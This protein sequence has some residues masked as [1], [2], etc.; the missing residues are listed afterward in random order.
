MKIF[1]F[2]L[3]IFLSVSCFSCKQKPKEKQP[4]AAEESNQQLITRTKTSFKIVIGIPY[5]EV[6]RRFDNGVSFNAQGYQLKPSWK[7]SFLLDTLISVFSPVKKRFY[8]LPV[9]LD[10]D[11]IFNTVGAWFKARTISKD[12]LKFQVLE[13][14][15]KNINWKKSNV[16]VTFYADGY[17]KNLRYKSVATLR[18]TT[19]K[20]TA[21]IRSLAAISNRDPTKIFAAQEPV[22]LTSKSKAVVVT[23][24]KLK[25]KELDSYYIPETLFY[26]EYNITIHQAYADF[27]HTFAVRVDAKGQMHFVEPM[28]MIL[29]GEEENTI[30]VMKG[31]MAGYL[32]HYLQ[33]TPGKTLGIPHDSLIL[34][35]VRGYKN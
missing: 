2:L 13:V 18:Q 19:G 10:H 32:T 12:S 15:D 23:D 29:P 17:L 30:K 9:T 8:N 7:L 33:I 20:D 4:A 28:E 26:P 11:S 3:L 21:Y 22:L 34:V 5:T 6:F 31:I 1:L 24:A 14:K 35:V 16:F 27:Y 25:A